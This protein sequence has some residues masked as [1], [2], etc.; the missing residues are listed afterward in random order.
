MQYVALAWREDSG[1]IGRGG[2]TKLMT[3]NYSVVKIKPNCIRKKS[4]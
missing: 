2:R 1:A 4:I 3:F